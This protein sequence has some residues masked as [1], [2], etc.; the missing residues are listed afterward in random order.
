MNNPCINCSDSWAVD[1]NTGCMEFCERYAVYQ[2]RCPDCE[3]ELIRR[4]GCME[5]PVCG[6]S[7]CGR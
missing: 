7:R 5:C 3:I 4:N 1:S 2:G 6:Y